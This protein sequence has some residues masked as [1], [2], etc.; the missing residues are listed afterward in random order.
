MGRISEGRVGG[1]SIVGKRLRMY[2][3]QE[4]N[5]RRVTTDAQDPRAD[6]NFMH[7]NLHKFTMKS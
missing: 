5:G 3:S 1:E 7:S 2:G 6:T 4:G